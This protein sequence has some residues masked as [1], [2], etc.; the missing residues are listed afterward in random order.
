VGNTEVLNNRYLN[1]ES[2][3][4]SAPPPQSR[5]LTAHPISSPSFHTPNGP[6]SAEGALAALG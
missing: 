4:P 1:S 3:G 5:H 6:P 2:Q